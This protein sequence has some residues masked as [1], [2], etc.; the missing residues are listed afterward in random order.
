MESLA[1]SDWM[2]DLSNI[3]DKLGML[4]HPLSLNYATDPMHCL[5][6]AAVL[7]RCGSDSKTF[8]VILFAGSA[9][10]RQL[11]M[12]PKC[13]GPFPSPEDSTDPGLPM[14]IQ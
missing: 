14:E 2:R 12:F 9:L 7:N 6:H 13:L 8:P 11:W 5:L 4:L 1:L 10:P 3:C